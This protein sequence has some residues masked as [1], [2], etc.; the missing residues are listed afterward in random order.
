MPFP[1]RANEV[2]Y[3]Q[4]VPMQEVHPTRRVDAVEVRRGE[5]G[6]VGV[7]NVFALAEDREPPCSCSKG[8]RIYLLLDVDHA[9][10]VVLNRVVDHALEQITQLVGHLE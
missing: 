5:G 1:E 3:S 8:W 9:A 6:D 10:S 4:L 2:I 7:T